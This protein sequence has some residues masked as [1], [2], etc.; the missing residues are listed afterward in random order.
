VYG[1]PP[2]AGSRR[3]DTSL[4]Q[5]GRRQAAQAGGQYTDFFEPAARFGNLLRRADDI[6]E[7]TY[8]I[9]ARIAFRPR[10]CIVGP[11][12]HM[13]STRAMPGFE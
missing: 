10:I 5:A 6:G 8:C 9:F 4:D 3:S 13:K 7:M 1:A 2:A 11:F 12:K